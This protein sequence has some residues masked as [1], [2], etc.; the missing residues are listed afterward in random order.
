MSDSL[1]NRLVE[2]LR[3]Q[4]PLHNFNLWKHCA[5][6]LVVLLGLVVVLL[7]IRADYLSAIQNG[8]MFWKPGAFFLAGVGCVLLVM[9]LSRPAGR[10][11]KRHLLPLWGAALI[12]LWQWVVQAERFSF[13]EMTQSL[14]DGSAVFCLPIVTGGGALTTLLLW[15][16]WLSKTASPRPALLGALAGFGAGCLVVTAYALHCDH[17]VVLYVSLCYGAPVVLLSVVAALLGRRYLK[18]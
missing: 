14:Y 8:A 13:H 18:W 10:I 5:G 15:K 9:D 1:V 4:T 3:P 12:L 16:A 6:C 2:D 17:D 7:G 11:R